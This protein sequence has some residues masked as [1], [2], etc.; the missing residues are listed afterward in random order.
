MPR[1][2]E[3]DSIISIK[4]DRD[5]VRKRVS[6]FIPSS[7][8][9]G[10]VHIIFEIIDNSVDELSIDEAVGNS[11]TV[12]FD[13]KTKEV[14]VIDDGRGIP[15]ESLLDVCTV[16]NTSG[17]FDNDEET[18]YTYSG[19]S[20]GV[21]FKT[22]V[23]LSKSCEVTSVRDGKSLTYI[24]TDGLLTDTKKGKS[25]DHGTITKFTIDNNLVEINDVT[26]EMI[27]QRI[28]EK[29]YCFPDI[30]IT[31]IVL[32]NGKEVKIHNYYGNTLY[33][34]AKKMKPDT[35]I[36]QVSDTRKVKI[37][38]AIDDDDL[39]KIT[40]VVDAAIAFKEDALD[41]DTGAFI[42]SYANSIKTYDGGEHV[43]GL[44]AGMVKFYRE[45][46]APKASKKD[47]ELPVMPSD[48]T[49]GL[50][51]VVSVKL[52]KPEFSAQH[53]SR[54]TN[55]EV[56]F[57]V[58]D[59][60]F[61]AMKDQKPSVINAMGDFIKRVTRGRL[62]SKKTRKKDVENAF[63]A[64]RPEKFIPIVYSMKTECPELILV[65]G[66]SAAG[67]ASTARD[68]Y[69]QA[70]YMVK[71]PKNVY[72]V[73]I[74]NTA[75][76]ALG[77][78]NEVCDICNIEPGSKCDP[79]KS[80]MQL[81]L[82]LT[83]GDVDGDQISVSFISLMAKHCRPLIDA[84]MV[85]RILPPAYSYR[86]KKG[87]KKFVRSKR[88]FFDL[89]MD[90]FVNDV[91]V[92]AGGKKLSP[93]NLYEFLDANF[94]YDT[95]LEALADWLCCDPKILEYIL[96]KY[97][98][99]YK[100]QK[101]SYWMQAMKAYSGVRILVENGIIVLD[102][103]LP[104]YGYINIAF[105]DNFDKRIHDFKAQQAGNSQITGYR[106]NNDDNKSLYDVMHMFRGYMPSD[107]KR[108]KGLGELD[109]NE[110]RELCMNREKR[111]V[112]IFK[113][114][115]FKDDMDK[116]DIIMSTKAEYAEARAKIVTSMAIKNRDLDT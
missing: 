79:S 20:F 35:E 102:G 1:K 75:R 41:A 90:R 2:Y 10:A 13:T 15:H 100:D 76:K 54:L 37:L 21:G 73:D 8:V 106:I 39:S 83:D 87:N 34:L 64:D 57:A 89:I 99:T 3:A 85:G 116:I 53:K 40:I 51:G 86:T 50:C 72:D 81:I 77:V 97:H 82:T 52:S 84:G 104:G 61:E 26:P 12:T 98:G 4:N 46:I 88:E 94:E 14:T 96:W 78:F 36:V 67:G 80:T 55:Q 9:D 107:V 92:Y 66:D 29:S 17:K 22:A 71:K 42:T 28:L 43:E 65:E 114:K 31:F 60:V 109:I 74:D 23:F 27:H 62:A 19:G 110:L 112:I 33:D 47:K 6:M 49:A 93:K 11:L 68:R 32:E 16:L 111:T 5:R 48:I 24:F 44:R 115:D 91:A 7:H 59:A 108:Y 18:A 63:S 56:R 113:F 103:E 95:N 70:I 101:K 45:V 30:N 69:N 58:R 105:N 38:K 25:K